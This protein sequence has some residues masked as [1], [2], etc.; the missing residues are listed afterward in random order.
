LEQKTAPQNSPN[1]G[2]VEHVELSNSLKV[3]LK[4]TIYSLDDR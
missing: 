1:P 2:P 3:S 4:S